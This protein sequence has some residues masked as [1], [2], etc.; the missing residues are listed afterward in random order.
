MGRYELL[1]QQVVTCCEKGYPRLAGDPKTLEWRLVTLSKTGWFWS[2]QVE[3][4]QFST[5]NSRNPAPW[6]AAF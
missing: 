4:I 1:D 5:P 6:Y 3:D 2:G